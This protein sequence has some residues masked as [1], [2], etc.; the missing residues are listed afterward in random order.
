[1][2]DL[3]KFINNQPERTPVLIKAALT[4]VQFETIHPFLD[5]NGRL[6]RLL[7]TLLLCSE[8]ALQE[9]LLYL[10]LYFKQNREEYYN[11]LDSV[12]RV[13]D[14]LGWLQFF[15]NGVNDTA[16]QAVE[17]AKNIQILF[18][19]D[20]NKIGNLNL[21]STTA[22]GI[23]QM[24]QRQPVITVSMAASNLK[25]TAPT[26]RKAIENLEEIGILKEITG[27]KRDRAYVYDRYIKILSEG[28]ESLR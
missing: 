23:H 26:T 19:R 1:M 10:S 22:L 11:Q 18:E 8:G 16:Q 17:T 9:P 20:R 14:W 27:K 21:R 24:L 2:G 12:R 7:I 3:E 25:K 6:G 13:G 5:G 4:H 15:L 28:T